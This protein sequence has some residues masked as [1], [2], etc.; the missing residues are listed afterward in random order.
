VTAAA[1]AQPLAVDI[2]GAKLNLHLVKPPFV[3][4]KKSP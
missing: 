4:L 3:K 1:A 2:R